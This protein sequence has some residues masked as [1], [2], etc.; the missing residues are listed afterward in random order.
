MTT[1][2]RSAHIEDLHAEHLP[3]LEEIGLIDFDPGISHKLNPP[4]HSRPLPR[5]LRL[6]Y[7]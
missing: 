1:G 3:F 4:L 2:P 7:G 5:S 6:A